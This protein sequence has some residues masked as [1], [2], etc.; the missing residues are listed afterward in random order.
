MIVTWF[1]LLQWGPICPRTTVPP[2]LS[3]LRIWNPPF[4][5]NFAPRRIPSSL[6]RIHPT[7]SIF[8]LR[9]DG[10]VACLSC[11]LLASEGLNVLSGVWGS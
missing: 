9:S 6:P 3:M 10:G 7:L 1:R 2:I 8:V 11:G 4:N 5:W